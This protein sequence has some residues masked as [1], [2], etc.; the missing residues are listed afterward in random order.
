MDTVQPAVELLDRPDGELWAPRRDLLASGPDDTHFVPEVDEDGVAALRFGDGQHGKRAAEPTGFRANYRVGNG[1]RGNVGA[2][3][4]THVVTADATVDGVVNPLAAAGG[5][6][7]ETVEEVRQ[8]APYLFR[9]QR[10]A[11]TPD[12][13]ARLAETFPDPDR[14][15]VQRAVATFRWT[16][17]WRTVFLSID[18][19]GGKSVTE[20]DAAG[21]TFKDRLRRFLEPFRMAGHDL[22][23]EGPVYV[24]LEVEMC[25]V[26]R[27]DAFRS[28]VLAALQDV[29]TAGLRADGT[30]GLFHPDRLTFG[31][32]VYLGTL[33]AAAQ[34]VPGVAA[35]DVLKLRR[36]GLAGTEA[37]DT[38]KLAMHRLEVARLD[39]DPNDPG[40]GVLRLH[41]EGGK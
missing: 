19:F 34:R 8:R 39:A 4:V 35:V 20:A 25:V 23:V 41:V 6:E 2:G 22:E 31:Q 28:D 18:R 10:R 37:F 27:P 29:F 9:T 38:G 13:Y 5:R 40:R 30:P 21:V 11:V 33:Y 17:S 15:E 16:G 12:D 7:P 14:P 1:T 36:F 3:T 32:P 26:A 24:P